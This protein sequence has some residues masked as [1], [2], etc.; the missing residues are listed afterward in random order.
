MGVML[1]HFE[2]TCH[3]FDDKILCLSY[4]D[5]QTSY[6]EQRETKK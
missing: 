5:I 6:L 1:S 3:F 2:S 4:I